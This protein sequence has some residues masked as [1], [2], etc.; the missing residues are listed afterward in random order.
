[1]TKHDA[2]LWGVMLKQAG[3]YIEHQQREVLFRE[4]VLAFL[5]QGQGQ[6]PGD[7]YCAACRAAKKNDCGN[8]DRNITVVETKN[9]KLKT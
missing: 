1:V 4:A 8:C 6:A 5:G 7:K 9:S 2:V 3:P